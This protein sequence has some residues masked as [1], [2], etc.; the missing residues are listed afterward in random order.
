[1]RPRHLRWPALSRLFATMSCSS[2][3]LTPS[4]RSCSRIYVSY[5]ACWRPQALTLDTG[6]PSRR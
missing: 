5:I 4:I 3:S 6:L 2:T 1:M